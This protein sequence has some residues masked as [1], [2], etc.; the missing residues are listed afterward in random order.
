MSQPGDPGYPG[1]EEGTPVM[2]D[3]SNPEQHDSA[4]SPPPDSPAATQATSSRASELVAELDKLRAEAVKG[5]KDVTAFG[6]WRAYLR[7][8]P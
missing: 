2:T 8:S 1:P 6:G 3:L 7:S 5:A 4:A